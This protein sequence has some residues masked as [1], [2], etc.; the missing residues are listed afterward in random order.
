MVDCL[1]IV[2]RNP[3]LLWF[4]H[5]PQKLVTYCGT[6]LANSLPR[7]IQ[8]QLLLLLLCLS[9]PLPPCLLTPILVLLQTLPF[10]HYLLSLLNLM[11]TLLSSLSSCISAPAAPRVQ[12]ITRGRKRDVQPQRPLQERCQLRQRVRCIAGAPVQV[13]GVYSSRGLRE[14]KGC[15]YAALESPAGGAA[16]W[17]EGVQ[18]LG[19]A[20]GWVEGQWRAQ[21]VGNEERWK[22]GKTTGQCRGWELG[23]RGGNWVRWKVDKIGDVDEMDFLLY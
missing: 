17:L 8:Q 20:G 3:T 10:A 9:L 11:H 16:W 6:Q 18:R 23:Q 22:G 12:L 1:W 13:A 5:L 21:K 7:R 4:Q 15:A 19:M 14:V 2:M